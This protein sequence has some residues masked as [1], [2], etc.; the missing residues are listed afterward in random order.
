M[1]TIKRTIIA[2]ILLLAFSVTS[3]FV[4]NNPALAAVNP[5]EQACIGTG[6]TWDATAGTCGSNAGTDDLQTVIGT[7]VNA[8]LFILGALSVV[9]III[10]GIRYTASN[11]DPKAAEAG[12]N[13]VLYAVIGL[14]IAFLAYAIVNW[15]IGVFD[16]SKTCTSSGGTYDTT[17][18]VCTPAAPTTP[19]TP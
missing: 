18:K 4:F 12:R 5:K 9:M 17:T 2:G 14:V 13:T 19:T 15:V 11:G 6:G 1:K 10:G 7:I 3:L 8:I 16:P